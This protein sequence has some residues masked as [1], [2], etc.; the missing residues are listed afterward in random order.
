M[1][2][3][4]AHLLLALMAILSKSLLALVRRH[5]VSLMLL[6]VGHSYLV[7]VNNSGCYCVMCLARHRDSRLATGLLDLVHEHLSGLEGRNLVLGDDDGRV[8]RLSLIHI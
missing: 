6:S 1:P 4:Q 2:S 7:L 5:L 3:P 8:L